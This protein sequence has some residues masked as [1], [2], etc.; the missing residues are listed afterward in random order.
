MY[1]HLINAMDIRK[2]LFYEDQI[3]ELYSYFHFIFSWKDGVQL[4]DSMISF[5]SFLTIDF[6]EIEP[7]K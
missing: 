1:F 3:F 7:I 6:I 4:T 2:I 5:S